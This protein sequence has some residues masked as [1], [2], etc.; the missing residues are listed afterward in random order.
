MKAGPHATGI[1]QSPQARKGAR[2]R[3]PS[4][5]LWDP[6]AGADSARRSQDGGIDGGCTA[7]YISRAGI[8]SGPAEAGLV[9]CRS[10]YASREWTGDSLRHGRAAVRASLAG[11]SRN[12]TRAA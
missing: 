7:T 11:T 9:S 8:R 2:V 4:R 3:R 10:D 6:L 5:V 12:G 1:Y